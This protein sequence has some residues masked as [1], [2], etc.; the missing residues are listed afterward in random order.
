MDATNAEVLATVEREITAAR[1]TGIMDTPVRGKFDFKHL[2]EIHRAI[3]QDI[4]AW[5]GKPRSVD[6]SKGNQFCLCRHIETFAEN[7]FAKLKDDQYLLGK[8]A[9]EMPERLTYYFSEINALH[10]A[11]SF[12]DT[13]TLP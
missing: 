11:L 7:V 6:I 12:A 8:T 10:P 1:I 5:A 9:N 2:R 4:F 13:S 3:F